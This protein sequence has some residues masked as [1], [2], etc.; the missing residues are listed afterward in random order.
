MNFLKMEL[1]A[2]RIAGRLLVLAIATVFVVPVSAQEGDFASLK[3]H[4]GEVEKQLLE[5]EQAI[6]AG[7]AD[8]SDG[9]KQLVDSANMLINQMRTTGL[10]EL[11]NDPAN[12]EVLRTLMGIMVNDA[13]FSRDKEVLQLG[14]EL[15][16]LG[17]DPRYFEV[18][19]QTERLNIG[20]REIFEELI[21]RQAEAAKDDLPRARLVTTKGDIVLELFEDQ[22]PN[23]VANFVNLIESGF[24]DGLSFHRVI[25]DFM[26]QSGD[27]KGDGSGGPGYTIACECYSPEARRHFTGSLSMAKAMARD[28]G[29]SQFFITFK[30]TDRLDGQHTVFGRVLSGWDVLDNLARTHVIQPDGREVPIPGVEKDKITKAEVIRKRDHEYKPKKVGEA[31]PAPETQQPP[32]EPAKTDDGDQ[33]SEQT[34]KES[35]D[36]NPDS[37]AAPTEKQGAGEAE[38]KGGGEGEPE[39][40]GGL[41]ELSRIPDSGCTSAV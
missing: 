13:A 23:T 3:A 7:D 22:A 33:D 35:K 24:Y 6:A 30:R 37:D 20:A 5:K 38:S 26:A 29:G 18:A 14:D 25:E 16:K 19:A 11:K 10:E 27:P 41:S 21:I 15:I 32:V 2:T 31:E 17:I 28:T 8:A 40:G 1:P 12:K 39:Q 4:W 9:F 34:N 36:V